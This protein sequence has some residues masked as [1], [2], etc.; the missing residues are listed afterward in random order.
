MTTT[1]SV[2]IVI[3]GVLIIGV[4][5]I[6]VFVWLAD[7]TSTASNGEYWKNHAREAWDRGDATRLSARHKMSF[8][9]LTMRF[10]YFFALPRI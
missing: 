4:L 10:P 2:A 5:I 9:R 8:F 3:I 7:P 6:A 1:D